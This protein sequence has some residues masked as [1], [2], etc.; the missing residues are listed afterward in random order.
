MIQSKQ[1]YCEFEYLLVREIAVETLLVGAVPGG[2]VIV[3]QSI[4]HTAEQHTIARGALRK[5]TKRTEH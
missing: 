4:P 5:R 1:S 2:D 3:S